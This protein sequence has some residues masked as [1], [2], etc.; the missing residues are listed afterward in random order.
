MTTV[1]GDLRLVT[2]VA[3]PVSQ[4]WVRAP[5]LRAADGAV[6]APLN[7]HVEV[8]EGHV[9]FECRPGPARVTLIVAG[10]PSESFDIL[11]AG[12]QLDLAQ[13][14]ADFDVTVGESEES[15]AGYVQAMR[16][17][18]SAVH[19]S[20]GV[21]SRAAERAGV[22]RDEAEGFASAA[23]D[24]AAK[25]DERASE[26]ARSRSAASADA[27]LAKS[28]Q[29]DA[30]HAQEW[31]SKHKES[32]EGHATSAESAATRS[33]NAADRLWDSVAW[34]GDRLSVADRQ[35]ESLTGPRGPRGETGE[36]GPRG[37]TGERGPQ[38][39]TGPRGPAGTV[40]GLEPETI[41]RTNSE[42]TLGRRVSMSGNGSAYTIFKM[43]SGNRSV[44]QYVTSGGD[45]GVY[46]GSNRYVAKSDVFEHHTA[47]DM[48][49]NELRGLPAPTADS[50]A[51]TKAYVDSMVANATVELPD[52][53]V[54]AGA[55]GVRM[56]K[57][58]T[59]EYDGRG[60][61]ST[62]L[63]MK[64]G[65]REYEFFANHAGKIGVLVPQYSRVIF[66]ADQNGFDHQTAVDMNNHYLRG[67]PTPKGNNHAANK[68][69][70]D[71]EVGAVQN[72]VG[73]LESRIQLVTALPANPDPN[74][75]YLVGE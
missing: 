19:A 10:S 75:L 27:N 5:R 47:T 12:D 73:E 48:R 2:D 37:A 54:R 50:H 34:N 15:L 18:Q 67:L 68:Q 71:K 8:R 38:G 52:N 44:E 20:E 13:A 39:D 46:D 51:T 11:V 63:I 74:T 6:V 40:D 29:S 1:S 26:A 7:D 62:S 56:G 25:A 41:V 55:D 35:S 30:R 70:V 32:A 17:V 58:F 57:S 9:S 45:F 64:N 31:A 28:A 60:N 14:V 22:A 72:R 4:V 65:L 36:R 42:P 66:Q 53:L 33:E 59:L 61:H 49:G 16:E 69:Y 24:S 3:A 43:T 23:N 21:V